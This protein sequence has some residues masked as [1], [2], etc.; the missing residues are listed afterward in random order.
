MT[1]RLVAVANGEVMGCVTRHER[2][3]LT[4]S[5][6]EAWIRASGAYPLSLSMPLAGAEYGHDVIEPWLWGLLPDNENVL[7]RWARRYHVSARSAFSLLRATGEDCPGGVQFAAPDRVDRLLGPRTGEVD[8]LTEEQVGARLRA[9]NEDGS[10]WRL[11]GDA[12]RFSL[13]GVQA[14][15]ALYFADGRWGVPRGRTPTTHILKPPISGLSG[16]GENEHL[17]LTLARALGIPA[18]R[19][20]VRRFDEEPALVVERYDRISTADGTLRVHQEDLCQALGLPPTAKYEG[21]GGPGCG[22]M[23]QAI[24]I[25]SSRPGRDLRTFVRAL[26]LNW[27]I[28]GTDA[29]AKNFSLLIGAGGK[30][31]LAPL[32]DVAS[33]LPYPGHYEPRL[34]LAAKIGGETRLGY[35]QTRHWTR[36]AGEVGLPAAEVLASCETVAVDVADRLHGIVSTARTEGLDHAILGRLEERIGTRATTCRATLTC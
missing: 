4:F 31:S 22:R 29:H 32:Y 1:E 7:A 18:A 14:K 30:A 33:L 34:K 3:R 17:C 24:R 28:G 8:W 6:D 9:L 36:F 10:A 2:G 19:S 16:H 13:A 5:Y 25:Y 35:I 21:D 11:P 12:G 27:I 26:V 15:T 23:A 20:S